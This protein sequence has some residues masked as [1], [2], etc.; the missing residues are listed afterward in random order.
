MNCGEDARALN[1]LLGGNT[2]LNHASRTSDHDLVMAG[3]YTIELYQ[4]YWT[5]ILTSKS[6]AIQHECVFLNVYYCEH[7]GCSYRTQLYRRLYLC[8]VPLIT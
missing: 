1:N 7:A 5:Q 8:R 4:R 6:Q 3:R 2:K